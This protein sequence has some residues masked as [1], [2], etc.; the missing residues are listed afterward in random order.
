MNDLVACIEN[1]IFFAVDL[2][3]NCFCISCILT[4]SFQFRHDDAIYMLCAIISRS[5]YKN[6]F[7]SWG[8]YGGK[9]LVLWSFKFR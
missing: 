9:Y 7:H 5:K 6:E 2:L 1:N 4:G 8:T 3:K